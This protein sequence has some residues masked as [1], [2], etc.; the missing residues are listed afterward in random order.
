MFE[1]TTKPRKGGQVVLK[2]ER[3]EDYL[4]QITSADFI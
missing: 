1:E 2:V 4:I 3:Q